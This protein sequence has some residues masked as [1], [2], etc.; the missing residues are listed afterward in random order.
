MPVPKTPTEGAGR[1]TFRPGAVALVWF[2]AGLETEYTLT[3]GTGNAPRAAAVPKP[4][5]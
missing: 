1:H 4:G 3:G 2:E 5:S